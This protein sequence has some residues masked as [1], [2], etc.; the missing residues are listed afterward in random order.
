[1]VFYFGCFFTIY[2]F[3]QRVISKSD[4]CISASIS[5]E[6]CTTS[7][8]PLYLTL[9]LFLL[10]NNTAVCR[11]MFYWGITSFSLS[12]SP[13]ISPTVE[14]VFVPRIQEQNVFRNVSSRFSAHFMPYSHPQVP[15][16]W[17]LCLCS[18][19]V[20]YKS[21]P[22]LLPICTSLK[23]GSFLIDI[24]TSRTASVV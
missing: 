16:T 6:L 2:S 4:G 18:R 9:N 20:A 24:H 1:M 5:I 12:E 22:R 17:T 3:I 23:V 7:L 14:L 15:G 19:Q 10:P 21:T 8:V 13:V 11:Y